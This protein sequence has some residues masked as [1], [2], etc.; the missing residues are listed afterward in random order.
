MSLLGHTVVTLA[1]ARRTFLG[2]AGR[3]P[4]RFQEA[5]LKRLLR[6]ARDTAFGKE[7]GFSKIRS[8]ADFRKRVPLRR[9]QDLKPWFSRAER[10]EPDV[11]WPGKIRYFGMSSG[12]TA[13]NKY[14]PISDAAIR[15]QQRGG[16]DPVAVY[17]AATWDTALLDGKAIL[18]GGSSGLERNDYGVRIGDNTGIMAHHVPRFVERTHLPSKSVRQMP[19]WDQRIDALVAESLSQDVRLVAG[20]P[21]WFPGLFDR[22]LAGAERRGRKAGSVQ[23]IWPHLSLITGGGINYEPYRRLIEARIG[24]RVP[25]VDVYNA[26]EGG[27]M[28]VQDRLSEP[29]MQLIPD[30]G[31]FYEFVALD[32]LEALNPQRLSLWEVERD[33]P[34]ALLVNTPSGIFGYAIGDCLRFVELFPHRFR[35]EGRTAAFL[36]LAGEHVCQG[37]LERAVSS[38]CRAHNIQIADFTVVPEVSEAASARHVFF[39]EIRAG[40]PELDRF[41]ADVDRDLCAHNG[42]YAAHRSSSAGL[43]APRVRRVSPGTFHDFMKWKGKLG[44]QNK[45]PRVVSDEK[46]RAFL[47]RHATAGTEDRAADVA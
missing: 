33:V 19:D 1:R 13:G 46:E 47:E 20:T 38:A 43:C 30:C 3:Y 26:T 8:V 17:L 11:V 24:S 14:L 31:V 29:L 42:D 41:A 28:G 18:L 4:R 35:F 25:Y 23:Q 16:F 7:H 34:Y 22:L 10:G 9:Y 5:T 21:S 39:V 15:H 2:V 6:T 32:E 36:N 45:V 12:T 44:G 27:I 40:E 37:E